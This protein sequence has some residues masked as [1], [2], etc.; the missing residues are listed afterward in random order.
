MTEGSSPAKD[1]NYNLIR[2]LQ[3]SLQNVWVLEQYIQ[4]ADRQGDE[5]L[6]NWFREIQK[7]N[8]KAGEQGKRLL[9]E[10]LGAEDRT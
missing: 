4:D 8:Q 3:E 7:N 6:A 9:V 5:A 10:R 1:K 2:V